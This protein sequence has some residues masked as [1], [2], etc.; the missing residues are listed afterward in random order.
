NG[1]V[2]K[3]ITADDNSGTTVSNAGD[4]N[5]DGL[6]DLIIGAPGGN[7]GTG[8]SYVVFGSS[9]PSSA[10]ELSA[11]DGNNGFV[12]KGI[13]A[14]DNS[15]RSVSSAGDVNGDGLADLIIGANRANG[16]TGESYVV[17][18]S[19]NPS[20]AIELSALDG[21]NGFVLNGIDP[22]DRSGR[23]VSNAGDVNGDGL[24]DLII[25][26]P[27]GNGGTGESYVVFGSSNPSSAIE[28]SA[29]N[30]SNGFV[31]NGIDIGDQSGN[32]VSNSGDLNGDGLADLII[33]ANRANSDAGESYVV[34]GSSN[35]SSAIE[36][37]ALDGSN[38]FVLNGIS[39]GDRSGI[40]VSSAFDVNGDGTADLIIGA[41]GANSNAG[42]SYVVFGRDFNTDEDTPFNTSSVLFN[43]TDADGDTLSITSID[44]SST[45]GLVL[46]NGDGTFNYDPD[47]RFDSLTDGETATDTFTYTI[48]DGTSTDTATV[49]ITINGIND[50]PIATDDKFSTDEDT[51]FTT[52]NVLANDSDPEDDSF[53]LESIDTTSTLGLV[54]DNGNGTFDYD[55]NGQFEFLEPGEFA[56]DSF[57]YKLVDS[58]GEIAH[59]TVKIVIDGVDDDNTIDDL[60]LG[61]AKDDSIWGSD[62]DD[63]ITGLD[64]N[65]TLNGEAG[66]DTLDGGNDDDSLIGGPGDDVLQGNS[67]H[68]V[69]LGQ[70]GN[71][72]LGGSSGNDTLKGGEGNDSLRGLNDNDSL[73]G[74]NGND[75]LKGGNGNDIIAGGNDNDSLHGDAGSDTLEG[76]AGNDTLLGQ[77]E[78]DLLFGQ[79]NNDSLFGQDGNDTLYGGS[80]DDTLLGQN[81]D[82]L[83]FGG[84][85]FD[86]LAGGFGNDRFALV[87]GD[88]ADQD[89]IT[90]FQ[91]GFDRLLL[92]GGLIF[93]NLTISQNGS[94][95]DIIENTASSGPQ[96]L[97][98]LTGIDA[99]DIDETDFV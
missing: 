42:E 40:S 33:G 96:T 75:T 7:G 18:G 82:D 43:D 24:A 80:G 72:T 71:D 6:A 66:N 76:G 31:L 94:D 68:D 73:A 85:G 91:D 99:I 8:E 5:G 35:P 9:N 39:A 62:G 46:N 14:D 3:G 49:T 87:S 36:L 30:G 93:G 97:A 45:L 64:G 50:A 69:L 98:T 44:T 23:S 15:G 26:A 53:S 17:F 16:G 22:D 47:G 20:S 58:N 2:L 95:T 89:I 74:D 52:D 37:S 51:P 41:S 54:T 28:L 11:L 60:F 21:S 1:F 84:L 38:G 61:T 70:G 92:T 63:T 19:S 48:S 86:S 78:A 57:G 90:D 10:I 56:T 27:G 13:T 77:D 55:P 29:L 12:L 32:V 88:T 65:D 59:G 81:N 79:E 34:F 4:V 67:G 25:G 83:L